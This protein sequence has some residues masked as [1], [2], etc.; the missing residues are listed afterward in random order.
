MIG[1]AEQL[2]HAPIFSEVTRDDLEFLLKFTSH[3]HHEEGTLL[4][5]QG[6]PGD[7]MYIILSGR[8]R[9]FT[10]DAQ[11]NQLT[12]RYYGTNEIVG[13]LALLDQE[14]R[15]TSADA[16]DIL[17]VLVLR[18]NDFLEFLHERPAVGLAM[19]RNLTGRVRYTTSY[20]EKVLD[21]VR[22]L[23]TGDYDRALQELQTTTEAGQIQGLISAFIEMTRSVRQR[24]DQLKTEIKRIRIEIDQPKRNLQVDEITNTGFF[25]HL[26]EEVRRLREEYSQK[27]DKPSD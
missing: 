26:S 7:A 16:A 4:F 12:I 13:E 15:S 18:R 24:E 25:R 19:M 8:I 2:Q 10:V 27:S 5:N 20:L 11:S 23:S 3:E 21:S 9:I 14:P 22:L 6:D 1:S 17:D